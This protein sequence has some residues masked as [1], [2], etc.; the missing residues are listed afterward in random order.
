MV[1]NVI[2]CGTLSDSF[3]AGLIY[4]FTRQN[5][6]S[7]IV[8]TLRLNAVDAALGVNR[9]DGEAD[10]TYKTA[11]ADAHDN[12]VEVGNLLKYLF[13]Y[14]SLTGDHMEVVVG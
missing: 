2:Q 5:G 6:L 13:S 9:V 1:T 12:V 14:C 4:Y 8:A 11:S 10:A 7:G 3:L